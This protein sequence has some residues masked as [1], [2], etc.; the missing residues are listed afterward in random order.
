M[1]QRILAVLMTAV[2]TGNNYYQRM[3]MRLNGYD[4]GLKIG[5]MV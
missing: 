5:N 1:K 3:L 2:Y 4:R